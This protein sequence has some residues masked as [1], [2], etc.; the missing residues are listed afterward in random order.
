MDAYYIR[1][2]STH[3][4]SKLFLTFSHHVLNVLL[5]IKQDEVYLIMLTILILSVS[6][7]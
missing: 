4:T 5:S 2:L 6:L 1:T 7:F 3:F